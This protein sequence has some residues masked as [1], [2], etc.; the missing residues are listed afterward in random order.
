MDNASH[1][2]TLPPGSP[3]PSP[4]QSPLRDDTEARLPAA[5]FLRYGTRTDGW[6]SGRQAAFLA[7]LAD[8]GVVEDAA[9]SVGKAL[10]GGYALRRQ[11]RGYAFSMGWE[12]AL[13]IARRIVADRLM[14]AAIKGEQARWVREEGVTT[15]TRQNTKLSLTLLDHVNPATTLTEIL[16]V[17]SRFDWFLQ[18]IDEGA[19]AESL[20]ALFFDDALPHSDIEARDRVR[21]ALLLSADLAGFEGDEDDN[22]APIEYKSVD[23]PIMQHPKPSRSKTPTLCGLCKSLRLCEKQKRGSRRGAKIRRDRR[24]YERSCAAFSLSMFRSACKTLRKAGNSLVHKMPTLDHRRHRARRDHQDTTIIQRPN[25]H[26]DPAHPRQRPHAGKDQQVRRN[27]SHCAEA[28]A[29]SREVAVPRTCRHSCDKQRIARRLH[30]ANSVCW[31]EIGNYRRQHKHR[32]RQKFLAKHRMH[33][34]VQ[35]E[36]P[37]RNHMPQRKGNRAPDQLNLQQAIAQ[38]PK[39]HNGGE[40]QELAHMMLAQHI[41]N[42]QRHAAHFPNDSRNAGQIQLPTQR[43][44][45]TEQQARQ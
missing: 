1:H 10:S 8:H 15:Y 27:K 42:Q 17:A 40:Q 26:R 25:G 6:N 3:P 22:N 34:P 38:S 14:S 45:Y 35:E 44:G 39:C 16:A 24:V 2:D 30:T 11:A 29:I 36:Q 28:N 23:G 41:P 12:A 4:P 20:W 32:K 31:E 21:T 37:D 18:L 19:D 43:V 13:L 7:H 33:A 9:R 5:A